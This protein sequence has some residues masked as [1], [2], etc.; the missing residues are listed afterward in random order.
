VEELKC[1]VIKYLDLYII[2]Q[3]KIPKWAEWIAQDYTGLIWVYEFEPYQADRSWQ[4][5]LVSPMSA[6]RTMCHC[7]AKGRPNPDWR[8]YCRELTDTE[9]GNSIVVLRT[10][11]CG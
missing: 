1:I 11:P 10:L 4:P 2:A 6:Y 8:Q 7:L 9:I 3:Y 5:Q